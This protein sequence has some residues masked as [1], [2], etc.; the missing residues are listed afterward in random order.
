MFCKD[1]DTHVSL[2]ESQRPWGLSLVLLSRYDQPDTL[3]IRNT[4]NK[5]NIRAKNL[6]HK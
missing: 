1:S 3:W 2:V 4:E 6:Q 5:Q